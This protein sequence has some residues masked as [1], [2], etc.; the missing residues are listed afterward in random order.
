MQNITETVTVVSTRP[1]RIF[2]NLVSKIDLRKV[3]T[4]LLNLIN[5]PPKTPPTN[6]ITKAPKRASKPGALRPLP[7]LMISEF[8]SVIG[9]FPSQIYLKVDREKVAIVE[10]KNTF[11]VNENDQKVLGF[12][13]S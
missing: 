13:I 12:E 11:Q 4:K 8:D 9:R 10:A 1:S 5:R 7:S 2:L 6:P 3:F